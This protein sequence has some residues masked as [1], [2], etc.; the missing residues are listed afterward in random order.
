MAEFSVKKLGE[1][2]KELRDSK[3]PLT[4]RHFCTRYDVNASTWGKL[5]KGTK[6]EMYVTYLAK[7]AETFDVSPTWLMFGKGEKSLKKTTVKNQSLTMKDVEEQFVDLL[8][9][10]LQEEKP[11]PKREFLK[12]AER[13]YERASREKQ[14]KGNV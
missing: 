8:K 2:L 13:A 14:P 10:V 7:L 4:L 6:P 1:R 11:R 3:G 12:I 9:E 5:E